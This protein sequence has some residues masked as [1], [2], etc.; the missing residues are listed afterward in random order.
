MR[1]LFQTV[2]NKSIWK[3]GYTQYYGKYVKNGSLYHI[4]LDV[5][6]TVKIAIFNPLHCWLNVIQSKCIAPPCNKYVIYSMYENND[7][8]S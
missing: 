3:N 1:L 2:P 7:T 8:F 4:I 5:R 6:S